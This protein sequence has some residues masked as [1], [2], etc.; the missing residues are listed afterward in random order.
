VWDFPEYDQWNNLGLR[1]L[2]VS[3]SSCGIF[4]SM[5]NVETDTTATTVHWVMAE[6]MAHPDNRKQVQGE[7]DTVVGLNLVVQES[8]IANLPLLRAVIKK[9]FR[10]CNCSSVREA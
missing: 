3:H 10:L 9:M 5:I 6:Q 2:R 8:D 1:F 7:I 4:Q